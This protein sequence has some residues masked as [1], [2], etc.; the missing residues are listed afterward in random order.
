M[1]NTNTCLT[2]DKQPDYK[3]K[4]YVYCETCLCKIPYDCV[5][6]IAHCANKSH[7]FCSDFC[8]KQWVFEK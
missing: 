4:R 3:E 7:P 8:Y 5:Y 6:A 1:G 2:R